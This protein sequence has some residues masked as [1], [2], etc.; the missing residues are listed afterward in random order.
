MH[1][2][3]EQWLKRC[4]E[5][6]DLVGARVIEVGSCDVNGAARNILTGW[7]S[8][9]GIDVVE[10]PGVDIVGDAVKV[11]LGQELDAYDVAVCTETFEHAERWQAILWELCQV[12][13]PGGWL[14]VTCAG[15]GRPEHAADGSP[16][17]PHPGE[18][19][20]NV[21]LSEMMDALRL[22]P[23]VHPR[24][25]QEGPPG[26]TR[27]LARKDPVPAAEKGRADAPPPPTTDI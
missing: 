23:D 14:I 19:Y 25:M 11:L 1:Y 8:W 2:E 17:G 4:A 7:K 24:M 9:L 13:R 15:T 20:R 16:N 5:K 22:A 18:Y 27:L 26:D 12:L 10:G 6:V 3:V 21:S